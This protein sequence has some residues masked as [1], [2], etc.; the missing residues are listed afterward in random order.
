MM[1]DIP[2]YYVVCYLFSNCSVEISLLPKVA[3]P[4]FILNFRELVKNLAARYTLDYPDHFRYRV[5]WGKRNQNVN[6]IF[7]HCTSIYFK[8]KMTGYFIKKLFYSW[9]NVFNKY[10]FPL[11]RA[12]DHM[13]C[14][15]INRMACSFDIHAGILMGTYPFYKPYGY[16]NNHAALRRGW[17]C[18][19]HLRPKAGAFKRIFRKKKGLS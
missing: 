19:F 14:G 4:K 11:F 8:I 7:R 9:L 10:L 5:S 1:I 17:F 2:S 13:I 16:G 18:A 3:S 12:P 15:F 6:M